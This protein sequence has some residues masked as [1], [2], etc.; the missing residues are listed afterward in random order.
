MVYYGAKR[1]KGRCKGAKYDGGLW[2]PWSRLYSRRSTARGDALRA[3]Q[4]QTLSGYFDEKNEPLSRQTAAAALLGHKRG[5]GTRGGGG[6]APFSWCPW[7]PCSWT[8]RRWTLRCACAGC[9]KARGR[10]T[11]NGGGSAREPYQRTGLRPNPYQI[12]GGGDPPEAVMKVNDT[13]L[14]IIP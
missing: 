7:E 9:K 12:Q 14:N 10:D 4:L 5:T 6:A 13:L 3:Q 1:R 2:T 11:A 8:R